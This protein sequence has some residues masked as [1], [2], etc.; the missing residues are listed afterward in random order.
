MHYSE[1]DVV[2]QTGQVRNVASQNEP[3]AGAALASLRQMRR[4][5]VYASYREAMA[6]PAY[7]EEM[8]STV[9]AFDRAVGDGLADLGR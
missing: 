6:H 4:E 9:A 8:E 2:E 1:I 5:K 7:I 3:T